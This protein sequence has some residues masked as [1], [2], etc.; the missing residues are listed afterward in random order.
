M[1]LAAL[2]TANFQEQTHGY[3]MKEYLANIKQPG[4]PFMAMEFWTG[5]FD[6]W[7][8]KHHVWNKDST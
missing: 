3:L 2:V 8:E 1:L 7:G 6:H 4:R 5:W